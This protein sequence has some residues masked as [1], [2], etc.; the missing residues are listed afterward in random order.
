VRAL[1]VPVTGSAAS[2]LVLAAL[3]GCGT[4]PPPRA[5]GP[6]ARVVSLA[7]SITEIVWALGAGDRLVGVCAQCDH[8]APVARVPRVG[9]YLVPSVE[10]VLAA[11]PDLVIV[12]PSPGNR[13]PVAT[14]ER[15]GVRILVVQDRTLADLWASMREI[16]RALGLAGAGERLV[17][18]V[19]ARLDE[20]RARVGGHARRRVLVVVGHDPL[21]VV[22]G[23]T[24]QDELVEAAGG[25]NVATD[26]GTVWP[27]V[28]RE[29]V[30]ARAPEV[31]I[32]AAMGTPTGARRLFDGLDT[33][34][35]VREGRIVRLSDD[36]FFRAGP[37]VP[38]AAAALARV[39]HPE[40]FADGVDPG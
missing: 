10:A 21:V 11:R 7:P 16:G 15:V 17:A 30:V 36:A 33:V 22:G 14:L 24:L 19:A 4:A 8:P 13:E 18:E 32:D 35:A 29:L 9:G 38:E 28:T 34:P 1:L 23:H 2:V 6:P 26:A 25:T 3:V 20:V 37:R 31:I 40:I 12:V 27:T 5:A 39:I